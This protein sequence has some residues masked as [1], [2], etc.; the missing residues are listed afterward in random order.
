MG[1]CLKQRY[2]W[3]TRFAQSILLHIMLSMAPKVISE[4]LALYS[5]RLR[6]SVLGN[7][8]LH[9]SPQQKSMVWLT[10]WQS[11]AIP[12]IE[13]CIYSSSSES[14]L[15][16]N[17]YFLCVASILM[18]AEEIRKAMSWITMYWWNHWW[19]FSTVFVNY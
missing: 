16:M 12:E 9:W 3:H 17:P 6:I 19:H 2:G 7:N 5:S 1:S 14:L 11:E 10:C 4:M 15:Y 13:Y 8:L 18:E